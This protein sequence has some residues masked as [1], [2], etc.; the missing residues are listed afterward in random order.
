MLYI[1]RG[2][3]PVLQ[4]ITHTHLMVVICLSLNLPYTTLTLATQLNMQHLIGGGSRTRRMISPPAHCRG[5]GE[6]RFGL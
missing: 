3:N 1:E 4:V 6:L 2:V 5:L